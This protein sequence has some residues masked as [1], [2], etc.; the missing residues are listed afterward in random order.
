MSVMGLP[1]TGGSGLWTVLEVAEIRGFLP[2]AQA[3]RPQSG[4]G[5][6]AGSRLRKQRRVVVPR[7]G[8]SEGVAFYSRH[9][10]VASR[11]RTRSSK[12]PGSLIFRSSLRAGVGARCVHR[13]DPQGRSIEDHCRIRYGGG[14]RSVLPTRQADLRRRRRC[15]RLAK[16]LCGPRSKLRLNQAHLRAKST[17]ATPGQAAAIAANARAAF[18]RDAV[19]ERDRAADRRRRRSCSSPDPHARV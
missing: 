11:C 14:G 5:G 10:E 7:G 17:A 15:G 6:S 3:F 8:A 4:P 1:S 18:G 16:R 19:G 12:S 2:G 13:P 9:D